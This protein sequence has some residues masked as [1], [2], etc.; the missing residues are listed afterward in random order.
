MIVNYLIL[1]LDESKN[2]IITFLFLKWRDE[3]LIQQVFSK[4]KTARIMVKK[5]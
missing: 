4:I 3:E 2:K 1:F 5:E